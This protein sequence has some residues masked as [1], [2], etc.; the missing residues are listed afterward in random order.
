V[1]V[2]GGE[3]AI[4]A[5]TVSRLDELGFD[6]VRYGGANRFETAAIIADSGLDGPSTILLATGANFPDA[7]AGGVAAAEANG[8]VLLANGSSPADATTV[9]LASHPGST[10]FAVGGAAAA[11]YPTA[12]PIVGADRFDTSAMLAERFFDGPSVVAVSNG[13]NYPDALSGGA[14]IGTLG[15]P[16]L[17]VLPTELPQPT[18]DYLVGNASTIDRA[19]VYGGTGAVNEVVRNAVLDAIS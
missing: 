9:Y 12:T 6:V 11:A 17:L 8:A 4:S 10:V 14:H 18:E 2:L 3:G 7:L 19:V 16:L 1:Y 5:A 15:G 13:A